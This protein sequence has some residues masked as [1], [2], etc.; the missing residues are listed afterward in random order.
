MTQFFLLAGVALLAP[1]LQE[2]EDPPR[3][4]APLAGAAFGMALLTRYDTILFLVPLA[5]ALLWGMGPARRS[6]PVLVALG[7]AACL[8]GQSWFHQQLVAPF[9]QPLGGMVG[10]FLA[11]AAILVAG[12]LL[13]RRTRPWQR[14]A[15]LLL[16]HGTALRAVAG[17]AVVSWALFGWFV[18]PRLAGQGQLGNLFRLV[19]G[20]PPVSGFARLLSG[21]ESGNMLYL[22]DL[23]GAVGLLAAVAGIAVLLFSRRRLWETAWLAASVSVL[24]LF[25]LNV[26]H[27]H[28][29]MWVSRRFV[30]VVLPLTS[31]GVAAA[32]A[33]VAALRRDRLPA[34][35]WAGIALVAAVLALNAGATKAMA[36]EREWPGLIAWYK[37][38]EKAIPPDAEVYCD[39]PGFAAPVRFISGRRAYEL[40]ARSPERFG[41]LVSVMRRKAA[42]GQEIFYLSHR[43][44]DDPGASGFVPVGTY[45]LRSSMLATSRRGV[46]ETSKARGADFVLYR[47]QP[48]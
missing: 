11:A 23:L 19:F 46:P 18:R 6:R 44:I 39:Q 48:S 20:D 17:F 32:A 5:A 13:L 40:N 1:A 36:R 3:A 43:P 31:I 25:T 42:E 28:F 16:P 47:V 4:A 22:V 34:L 8:G 45:P 35:R 2:D 29:L 26:F 21:N 9:Y 14:L 10:G 30:P 27:D 37:Q 12:V 41:G 33:W 24:A 38:L 7:V 15:G